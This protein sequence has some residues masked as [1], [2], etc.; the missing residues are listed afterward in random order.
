MATDLVQPFWAL[1]LLAAARLDF[2]DIMGYA[3]LV[4]LVYAA[5]VSVAFWL[6]PVLW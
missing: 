6:L 4:F 1:P 3:A 5:V 2:R